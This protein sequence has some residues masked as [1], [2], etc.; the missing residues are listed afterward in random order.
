MRPALLRTLLA[1]ALLLPA[2]GGRAGIARHIAGSKPA[3][4]HDACPV[5]RMLDPRYFCRDIS[6]PLFDD[7]YPDRLKARPLFVRSALF[8]GFSAGCGLCCILVLV[9]LMLR[10]RDR[11]RRSAYRELQL[12]HR[13]VNAL[14]NPH[15]LFNAIS[16]IQGLIRLGASSSAETYLHELSR[17]IRQ[18]MENLG[19]DLIPLSRELDLIDAYVR[20]QNLRGGTPVHMSVNSSGIPAEEIE[21]P[22]LLLQTFIENAIV[23]GRIGTEALHIQLQLDLCF[24]NYLLVMI[25]DNGRGIYD[26]AEKRG[27]SVNRAHLGI[28]FNRERLYRLNKFYGLKQSIEIADLSERGQ[29]GTEVAI[30]IS[31]RLRTLFRQ[32]AEPYVLRS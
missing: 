11:Q 21:L 5:L 32:S 9:A 2:A 10:Y 12:E 15:F 1:L 23:H 29:R 25:R 30:I 14:M 8:W 28:A 26:T 16:N 22:P 27:I 24:D 4:A 31:T 6:V 20:L 18:N 3:R 19:Q 7:P 13:A 17:M